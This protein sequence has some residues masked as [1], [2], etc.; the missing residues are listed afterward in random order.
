M[1]III[2]SDKLNIK[3]T[4]TLATRMKKAQDIIKQEFYSAQKHI[5]T[6]ANKHRRPVDF[7]V[8]DFDF[9]NLDNNTI[10]TSRSRTTFFGRGG[11]GYYYGVGGTR[12]A[13]GHLAE[14]IS[15]VILSPARQGKQSPVYLSS[16]LS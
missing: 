16:L 1:P 3:K 5:E 15:H 10:I 6:T 13:A 11:G 12:N 8:S 4:K 2:P 7:G 9:D 14:E